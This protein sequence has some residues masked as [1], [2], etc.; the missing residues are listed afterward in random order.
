MRDWCY[1]CDEART[2]LGSVWARIPI[3]RWSADFQAVDGREAREQILYS[4][5]KR[6]PTLFVA[7]GLWLDSIGLFHQF[8]ADA[9]VKK[10]GIEGWGAGADGGELGETRRADAATS[11]VFH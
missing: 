3:L 8:W 7:A 1:E 10:I 9:S 11:G 5:R 6:C 4:G 2:L